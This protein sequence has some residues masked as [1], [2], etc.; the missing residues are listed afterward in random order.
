VS[1]ARFSANRC[2]D[3]APARARAGWHSGTWALV[4][5]FLLPAACRPNVGKDLVERERLNVLTWSVPEGSAGATG[6][7]IGRRGLVARAVSEISTT[8]SWDQYRRWVDASEKVGYQQTGSKRM[9]ASFIRRLPGDAF[10]VDLEL[11]AP[12]PPLRVRMTFTA[13]P[14]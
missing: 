12:G 14:D 4:I 9:S 2:Q 3:K 13:T 10:R 6:A 8:M 1:P 7:A 11:V 5:P